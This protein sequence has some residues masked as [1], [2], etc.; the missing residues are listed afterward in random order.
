MFVAAS[1][2][3]RILLEL[4]VVLVVLAA[5]GR[6]AGRV[7]L[8]SIPM[9]LVSGLL[10]GE[11]GLVPLDASTEFVR[12]GADLGVIILL[13]LLG[14]EYSPDDLQYGLR[15][16][17]RAGL[18]DLGASALPGVVLG[19]VLGWGIVGAVLLGGITYVSSSGIVARQLAD[20]QRVGNRETPVVL[21]ILV[22]EDLVMAAFLPLVG[23]LILGLSPWRGAVSVGVAFVAVAVALLV[24]ARYS[25]RISELLDSPSQEVLLLTILGMTLLIGGLAEEIEV[26]A[27][28]AAFLIGLTLSGSVA[29]RGRELLLPVRDVFGGL[30]FVFFGLQID[31][32]TLVPVLLPAAGLALVTGATK[33]H[34]G[35]W[36]AARAGIGVRG[37]VRA[38]T[39]LIPRGEFSVVL[40]GLGVAAGLDAELGPLA[41]CYVLILAVVG[42]IAM[43]F[44]DDIPLPARLST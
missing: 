25:Q 13:L 6:I 36:A 28:V 27:A 10:M 8:P 31:P 37:R 3:G 5:V 22:I 38:A 34:T 12:V 15:S 2:S 4:G 23:V 44:A 32:T 29:Q 41:A 19:L 30:F 11:G 26:S 1:T 7:G 9:F 21:A 16:N 42:S 35:W 20:L 33:A 14:L 24:A 39:S 43:R 40:A 18:V 17:W